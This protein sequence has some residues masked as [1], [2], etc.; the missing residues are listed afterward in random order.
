MAEI[1]QTIKENPAPGRRDIGFGALLFRVGLP[2]LVAV[3]TFGFFFPTLY[4]GFVDWDDVRLL[5]E[6]TRYRAVDW[7][8][9]RWMFGTFYMGHYQPMAWLTFALDYFL[10]GTDPFG[11][12]LTS[13]IIHSINA[14]LF[15]FV[16]LRLL[17][18]TMGSAPSTG[19]AIRVA[20][21]LTALLF[22]IHPLRVE[23]VAWITARRDVLSGLFFLSTLLC[24]LKAMENQAA[25]R[26]WIAA[27]VIFYAL[28]LLSKPTSITLPV[29]LLVLDV[30]PLRRLVLG[31]WSA[32]ETRPIWQEKLPFFALA[33][34]FGVIALA[35][36]REAGAFLSLEHYGIATRL[37]QS[38]VAP[39]FYLWKMIAPVDL[40]PVYAI[41]YHLEKSDWLF[42]IGAVIVD[43]A[44]TIAL[45][46][47]RRRWPGLLAVWICYLALLAP[48][49]GLFQ[50]EPRLAADRYSYL[51]CLGWAIVVAAALLH[52][53]QPQRA[54]AGRMAAVVAASVVVVVL[55]ALTWRQTQIWHDPLTLWRH[56]VA[57]YPRAAKAE[58]NLANILI[59]LGRP[60]EAMAHYRLAVEIDPDYKEGRHNLGL[61]LAENGD[62]A[63]AVREYREALRIDPNYKEAHNSLAAALFYQ[64]DLDG[65]ISEYRR[66]LVADPRFKE[67]HN[68]LGVA[69]INQGNA[70]GAVAEYRAA[71]A[72]DPNYKEAHYNLGNALL[73]LGKIDE[74]IGEYQA[75]LRIDP[76]Y[77]SARNNLDVAL[78]E[79]KTKR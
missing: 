11:Y 44:I 61:T 54:R 19:A 25:R 12:H 60:A 65:A 33:V 8:N 16:A 59:Q 4:S 26:C 38:L 6:N 17:S 64:G 78:K 3:V 77:E 15:Y 29:V 34:I 73:E 9:I 66:A 31:R 39:V 47:G 41:P 71:L 2:L 45:I 20:A 76:R 1:R 69:L 58:N 7:P 40:S 79:Q 22:A 52:L 63:G 68:N 18:L 21:G 14:V 30:Y 55:G 70:A 57:A 36:Q 35:A 27:A 49:L 56:A 53:T 74:A 13:L 62:V 10:W 48:V 23:S 67:A 32:A 28:S 42:F 24:Y 72:L 43:V 46:A 37:G 5:L 75:A 51:S 50:S